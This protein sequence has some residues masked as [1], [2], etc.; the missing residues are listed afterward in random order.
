LQL[1]TPGQI[2]LSTLGWSYNGFSQLHEG[3][4]T[5]LFLSAIEQNQKYPRAYPGNLAEEKTISIQSK[6]IS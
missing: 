1:R 2:K 5:C 6:L 4:K 3:N